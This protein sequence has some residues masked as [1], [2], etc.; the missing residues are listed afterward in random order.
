MKDFIFA[1]LLSCCT[2][3]MPL[4][5]TAS[6]AEAYE[7]DLEQGIL[8]VKRDQFK[9][10]KI[11]LDR[12]YK[13]GGAEDFRTTYYRAY[14]DYKL[15]LLEQAF[16]M[17]SKAKSLAKE[18]KEQSTVAELEREMKSLYGAVTLNPADGETNQ[19]GRIFF[20]SKTGIINKEKKQR[21]LSIRE[22]FKSTD[23]TLPTT[24]YL[25]YGDYLVNKVPFSLVEGEPSPRLEIYLQIQ[26]ASESQSSGGV[27]P[28]WLVGVGGLAAVAAGVGAYFIFADDNEVRKEH[29]HGNF[30]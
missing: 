11:S 25:P 5:S 30:E 18:G 12:A 16:E 7:D 20:E 13:G 28:W 15:L 4:V 26:T 19:G 10:A 23:I 27:S 29:L 1:G 17:L 3:Y 6:A 2:V 21:F 14:A 24:V 9:Q 8:Y 22:R